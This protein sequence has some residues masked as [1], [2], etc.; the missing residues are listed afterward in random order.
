MYLRAKYT[1]YKMAK[2][3]F[4]IWRYVIC[5]ICK[6]NGSNRPF[7]ASRVA[8][9]IFPPSYRRSPPPTR[10]SM[11]RPNE[12]QQRLSSWAINYKG[13]QLLV[14]GHFEAVVDN[15]EWHWVSTGLFLCCYIILQ[16]SRDL[17]KILTSACMLKSY[18]FPEFQKFYGCRYW[19]L[20]VCCKVTSYQS[21]RSFMVADT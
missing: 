6:K 2:T 14:L 8:D 15:S 11:Q 13:Q 18:K 5:E 21:S 20:P 4:S 19:P 7:L 12:Q 16:K 3:K 9:T 17:I 1:K 10:Q